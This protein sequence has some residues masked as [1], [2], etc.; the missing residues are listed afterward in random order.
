MKHRW[1][2]GFALLLIAFT[3]YTAL[4][5]FVIE[6]VY[7]AEVESAPQTASVFMTQTSE[8]PEDPE[9]SEG[10][11]ET[12]TSETTAADPVVT[13]KSYQDENIT[14]T[15]EEYRVENTTSPPFK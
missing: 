3:V 1:T 12:Q 9:I 13:S 11:E 5:T 14:I 15:I 6:R 10:S 4:D 2:L 8:E 7:S